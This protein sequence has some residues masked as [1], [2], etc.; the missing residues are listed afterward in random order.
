ME[1]NI[2]KKNGCADPKAKKFIY[3]CQKHS[4]SPTKN[5]RLKEK[6]LEVSART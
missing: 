1:T 6:D 3:L 5:V 2:H 4:K